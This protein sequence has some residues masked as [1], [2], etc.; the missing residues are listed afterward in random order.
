MIRRDF[1]ILAIVSPA[2]SFT[3]AAF[4]SPN[5]SWFQGSISHFRGGDV[6]GMK[7]S[8]RLEHWHPWPSEGDR[9]IILQTQLIQSL[10]GGVLCQPE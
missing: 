2:L 3:Q 7:R 4:S 6:Y 5:V 10:H 9:F 1:L 8:N